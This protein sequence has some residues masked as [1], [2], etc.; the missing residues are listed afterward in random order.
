[1]AA[2][3]AITA[4]R[5]L[6]TTDRQTARSSFL[7]AAVGIH[8]GSAAVSLLA[9]IV[10]LDHGQR[11]YRQLALT[12]GRRASGSSTSASADPDLA[13]L[14]EH[15]YDEVGA[16]A[17]VPQVRHSPP[18]SRGSGLIRWRRARSR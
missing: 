9:R 10:L 1:M 7:T 2:A 8:T 12:A 15:L 18:L 13:R 4:T 14:S 17:S 5:P 11:P 3:R 16:V 6:V